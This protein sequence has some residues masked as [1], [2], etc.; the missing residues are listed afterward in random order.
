V[1]CTVRGGV[2]GHREAWLKEDGR[3][4]VGSREEAEREAA[5]LNALPRSPHSLASFKYLA[6]E[7]EW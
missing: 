4:W 1:W 7:R 6:M 2:T 5:R 3:E